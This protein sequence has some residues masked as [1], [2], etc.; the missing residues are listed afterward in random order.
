ML[1]GHAGKLDTPESTCLTSRVDEW[2]IN[3]LVLPPV[4][5]DDLLVG[6]GFIDQP[7]LVSFA[8]VQETKKE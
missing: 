8:R 5:L 3:G 6:D 7:V 4:E 1:G 2:E